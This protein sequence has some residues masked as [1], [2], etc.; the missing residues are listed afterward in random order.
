VTADQATVSIAGTRILEN[1][2]TYGGGIAVLELMDSQL[3]I[4]QSTI[5]G[6]HA[7]FD[8]ST[9]GE[10]GGIDVDLIDGPSSTVTVTSSTISGN[11]ADVAGGGIAFYRDL[12][13]ESDMVQFGLVSSTVSGNSAPE[14][15]GVLLVEE[16][17]GAA[18]LVTSIR[19]STIAANTATAGTGGVRLEGG[20][21]QLVLDHALIGD[22]GTDLEGTEPLD[23]FSAR[24]TLVELGTLA[25]PAGAGNLEGVDPRL[26][27]L[28]DNGGPTRTHMLL[29]SSPAFNAGDAAFAPPPGL[30][31]RGQPRV[32]QVI[33]IGA[34]ER[35]FALP[36][37]GFAPATLGGPVALALLVAGLLMFARRRATG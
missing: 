23:D 14:G 7:A 5:S 26:G 31:Q 9:G 15:A 35:R 25:L 11:R 3:D 24:F 27:P 6:N 30:D 4:S 12:D 32:F 17:T 19:H 34:L 20:E 29:D 36:A 18:R 28:A 37:T 33:D 13:S 16:G 1:E 21:Q 8:G 22:N 10:G 2:G